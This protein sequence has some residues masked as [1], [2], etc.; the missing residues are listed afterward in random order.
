MKIF[1]F[2]RK[3][4]VVKFCHFEACSPLSKIF[5]STSKIFFSLSKI[6]L[7]LLKSCSAILFC[8]V[9]NYPL[10]CT[11]KQDVDIRSL[12]EQTTLACLRRATP[13]NLN[14]TSVLSILG[15]RIVILSTSQ[16]LPSYVILTELI[17]ARRGSTN[18]NRFQTYERSETGFSVF[19]LAVKICEDVMTSETSPFS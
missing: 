5:F 1:F 15:R 8:Q 17:T 16:N 2:R 13:Q 3:R 19:L 7:Q 11:R 10:L 9:K 18:E 6:F 12:T 14:T 4:I